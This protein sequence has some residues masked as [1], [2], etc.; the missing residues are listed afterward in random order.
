MK[1]C[2]RCDKEKLL[3]EFYDRIDPKRALYDPC[4]ECILKDRKIKYHSDKVKYQ[5]RAQRYRKENPE[6]MRDM[7]LKQTY[8]VGIKYF[9]QK[10]E[11]QKGVCA[12]CR[13]NVKQLWKGKEVAMALDHDHKTKKPRGVLCIRSN[14]A[15]GLLRENKYTLKNLIGYIIKYQN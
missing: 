14:R 1:K 7:K 4:K 10:L 3:N 9:N 15:L 8:G 12:G 6:I 5:Q 2:K 11:E 13:Q